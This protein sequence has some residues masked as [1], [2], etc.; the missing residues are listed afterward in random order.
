ML[1]GAI[2]VHQVASVEERRAPVDIFFRTLAD[3]H[4]ARAVAVI[5]SGTGANGSMGIKR[6]KERGGA[7]FVQNPREAEFNEMPRNSIATEL[8]DAVLPV[9][10]IPKRIVAYQKGLGIVHIPLEPKQTHEEEQRAL[11]EICTQRT[12]RS[13]HDFT[14]YKRHTLHRRSERPIR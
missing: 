12:L 3:T 13:G 7:A 9:A 8:V 5:L 10:E 4:D 1:D 14:T 11:R 2:E 6:V